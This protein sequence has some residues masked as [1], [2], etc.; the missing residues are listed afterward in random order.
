MEI[1]PKCSLPKDLCMCG[2]I[3]KEEKEIKI[4]VEKR[5]Y[6]K[7]VTIV[8]GIEHNRLKDLVVRLKSRCAAGGSYKNGYIVLQGDHRQ[9]VKDVLEKEGFAEEN[10]V[11]Q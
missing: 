1:C 10:I 5:K 2:E 4:K 8:E 6:G 3:A 9:I 7:L 11:V